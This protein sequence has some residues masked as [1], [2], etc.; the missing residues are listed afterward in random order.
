MSDKYKN[1]YRIA[2]TRLQNWD[3]GW[4]AS[5][6]ITICTKNRKH[7]FGKIVNK[8]MQL[9]ELGQTAY[10]CFQEIPKHFPFVVLGEFVIMPNHVHGI[11]I[12]DK[13]DDVVGGN[14]S[15]NGGDDNDDGMGDIDDRMGGIDFNGGIGCIVETQ[16]LASLQ[17]D[18]NEFNQKDS[19]HNKTNQPKNKFGPQSKNLASIIRGY[20]TGVTKYA[21]INNINFEWQARF[22]DRIIRNDA[23]FRRISN[24][25]INNPKNWMDDEFFKDEWI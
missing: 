9:T 6:F 10:E 19:N 20:K 23:E 14:G 22:H 18:H 4:N 1:K 25:I 5:Y 3:Y 24:Y 13:Q 12:I 21:T 2:S 16:N 7:Y 8:K 15:V 11:I 17:S